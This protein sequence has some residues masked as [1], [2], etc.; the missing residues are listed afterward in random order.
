MTTCYSTAHLFTLKAHGTLT[1]FG[2]PFVKRFAL[3]YQTVVCLSCP[4]CLSCLS[5]TLVCCGQTVGW[6]KMKLGMQ[7]G[8]GHCHTV[9]DGTQLPQPPNF[10]PMS[11]VAKRLDGSRCHALATEVGLGPGDNVR[12]G[13]SPP[14]KKREAQ[15]PIFGT[16][17]LWPNGCMYQDTTWYRGRSQPRRHCVKWGPSFPTLKGHSPHQFS[18]IVRC[19]QTAGWIKTPLNM[20]V[21]LGPGD[22]VFDGDL[23]PQKKGTAPTQFLANVYCG[24]TA[25]WMKTPLGTEV[26]LGPGHIVLDENPAPP[27][28]RGTAAPRIFGPCLLWPRSP[29]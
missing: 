26:D 27:C 2:R 17:L 14:P 16:C 7:V 20:E 13:P 5:V 23:A 28:E 22:F 4:V 18:A 3:C 10:R 8:L 24:Q 1:T 29:I 19:G 21:G 6:I 9:F 12:W 25:G 15:P 11:Y